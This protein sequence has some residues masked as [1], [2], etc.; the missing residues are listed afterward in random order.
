MLAV[1]QYLRSGK[2]LEDLFAEFAI[3]AKRHSQY[4]NL[5]LL[6]YSQ[7]D[8]P[9][10]NPIVQECR[11]IILDENENW[12]VVSRAF[13]KF[14][15]YGEGHAAEIDWTTAKV[16]EKL[17]GSMM[18]VYPYRGEWLV[19]SSGSS[20]ASGTVG[21]E[22]FTFADL[23]WQ[24]AKEC[25]LTLP[26]ADT[27]RLC[28]T[29][30]LMCPENRVVVPHK[31]RQIV[32]IGC[33]DLDFQNEID[34]DIINSFL[35]IGVPSVQS[36]S[37]NSISDILK[38]FDHINPLSQEGYVVVDSAFNRI[39]VKHPGYV[40]IHHAKDGFSSKTFLE[41]IRSGENSELVAYFPEYAV[42]FEMVK[43]QYESLTEDIR[44]FWN[45]YKGIENQKDFA[46]K[47]K[48][49]P[50]SGI[51]F[52]L[53]NRKIDSIHQGLKETRIENLMKWLAL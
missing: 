46:M 6:K 4:P 41:V 43:R 22:S 53:R 39:K 7:I 17:D 40:A 36:F 47:V 13:D 8:S 51:L 19:Q 15:N 35:N 26:P 45:K 5:V 20:D 31:D 27:H 30:E 14:F 2:T 49:L 24:T 33:R 29:F 16:Q 50:F 34:V 48:N 9:M 23:F 18:V 52:A 12:K 10:G 3:S 25:G 44:N 28:F 11:G 38:S 42:E 32:L 37:L 1:Q 21:T